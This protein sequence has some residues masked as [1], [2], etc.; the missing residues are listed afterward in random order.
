MREGKKR[1]EGELP[2]L[3]YW[4]NRLLLLKRPDALALK[5]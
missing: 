1:K 5:R 3:S 4:E 2:A